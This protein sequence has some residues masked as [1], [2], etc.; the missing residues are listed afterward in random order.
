MFFSRITINAQTAEPRELLRL[1]RGDVYAVHQILWRLFPEDPDADRDFLFRQEIHNGWPFFYMVSLRR[2]QEIEGSIQVESKNY[3]PKLSTGQRLA[4]SLRVN[5]VVTKK[6]EDGKRRVRHDVV[7][8]AKRDLATAKSGI[9]DI[10]PGELQYA[11]GTKWLDTRSGGHGFSFDPSLVRVFGYQQHQIK[12]RNQKNKIQ[13]SVLDFSG[14]LTITDC[15]L[16]YRTLTNGI[17]RAKA[18]GCGLMLVRRVHP[19]S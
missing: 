18:F 11:A 7:M 6:T 14:L 12:S 13:F 10:S 17:G 8:N 19:S 5:P 3:Q 9:T 2:P 16:F 15:N 4:F 1:A